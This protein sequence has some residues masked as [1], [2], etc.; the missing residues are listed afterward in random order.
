MPSKM[1]P[2]PKE[3]RSQ[4]GPSDDS[5]PPHDTAPNKSV[6]ENID[7]QGDRANVAQN[8]TNQDPKQQR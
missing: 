7:Q 3:N 2:V 6:P 4:K 8:T 1:P 5:A